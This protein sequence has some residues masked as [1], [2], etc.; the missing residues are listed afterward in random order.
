MSALQVGWG[1]WPTENGKKLSS[2]QAQLGQAICLALAKLLSISGATSTPSALYIQ[3]IPV[4]VP[5]VGPPKNCDVTFDCEGSLPANRVPK[6]WWSFGH[7]FFILYYILI[8]FQLQLDPNRPHKHI[9]LQH[10]I[11]SSSAIKRDSRL[12]LYPIFDTISNN[13]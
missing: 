9:K 7:H 1:G 10:P 3:Y 5:E 11:P 8:K 2:S 13:Y 6:F 4:I 12:A